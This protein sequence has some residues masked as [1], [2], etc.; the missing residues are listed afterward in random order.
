MGHIT[1]FGHQNR[2]ET[3]VILTKIREEWS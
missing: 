1:D 3:D 2:D